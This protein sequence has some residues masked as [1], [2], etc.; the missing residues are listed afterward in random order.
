M[1]FLVR[2]GKVLTIASDRILMMN[3]TEFEADLKPA[4][5]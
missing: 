4:T 5:P 3:A 1:D 2:C